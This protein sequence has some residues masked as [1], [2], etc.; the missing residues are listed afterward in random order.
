M[1]QEASADCRPGQNQ[2][3]SD[4]EECLQSLIERIDTED[5]D[6]LYAEIASHAVIEARGWGG[7]SGAYAV[8]F[9]LLY[10]VGSRI[11]RFAGSD[12]AVGV[13]DQR[14]LDGCEVVNLPGNLAQRLG[15]R[16]FFVIGRNLNDQLHAVSSS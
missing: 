4:E 6:D 5:R 10:W 8:C 1:R 9:T 14:R 11:S 16:L 2:E 3:Q 7:G 12:S 13:V 15:D